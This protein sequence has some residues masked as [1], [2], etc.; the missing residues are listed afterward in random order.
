MPN[1]T[2]NAKTNV[3]EQSKKIDPKKVI[4]FTDLWNGYPEE[5]PCKKPETETW[6]SDGD[7]TYSNQCAIRVGISLQRAGAS[8][9][10]FKGALCN[11]SKGAHSGEKHAIR[12]QELATWLERRYL[13]NWPKGLEITGKDWVTKIEGKTGVAFFQDY[14]R[15]PGE[16]RGT[17]DHIDLWN[18]SRFPY[19]SLTSFG[20]N[21]GR[22]TLGINSVPNPIEDGNIYFDLGQAAKILFWH[23]P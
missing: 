22:F 12:A 5:Y 15:R 7:E 21:V 23:I 13:A 1:P 10:T 4:T 16:T 2:S 19:M 14:W 18:G 8:L 9:A 17:G 20:A 11:Y 6:Y 3:K